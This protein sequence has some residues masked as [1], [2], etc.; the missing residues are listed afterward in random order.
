VQ[1]NDPHRSLAALLIGADTELNAERIADAFVS[2]CRQIDALL[3]PVFG[4]RGAAALYKRSVYLVGKT[5][6][7][8]ADSSQSFTPPVEFTVLRSLISEQRDEAAYA[9]ASAFLQS[10]Y[11]LLAGMVGLSLTDQLLSPLWIDVA[12][13][14]PIQDKI[15]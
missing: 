5:H 7:W 13:D 3:C 1:T 12:A 14:P 4:Q 15:R 6:D 9:G 10:L 8:L 2:V 11:D